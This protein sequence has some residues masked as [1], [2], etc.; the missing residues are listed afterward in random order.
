MVPA[1][2]DGGSPE[3]RVQELVAAVF[4]CF[5]NRRALL[6]RPV[7]DPV[8]ELTGRFAQHVPAHLIP[9]PVRIEE[10]DHSLRLLKWLNQAIEKQ[11]NSVSTSDSGK[12]HRFSACT[13]LNNR[14][15]PIESR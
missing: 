10:S 11:P 14:P 3:V 9:L 13:Y 2:L 5:Q 4:R 7:H 6:L 15:L 1:D 12:A 8:L